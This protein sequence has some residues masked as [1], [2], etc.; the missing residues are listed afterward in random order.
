MIANEPEGPIADST[1]RAPIADFGA[2][3][4]HEDLAEALRPHKGSM[5]TPDSIKA[6]YTAHTGKRGS[7]ALGSDHIDAEQYWA[8]ISSGATGAGRCEHCVD[9][10]HPLVK[11]VTTDRVR[12]LILG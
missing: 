11:R 4:L 6:L 3:K 9:E 5:L 8:E 1:L 2:I 7:Y 10:G 12:Y